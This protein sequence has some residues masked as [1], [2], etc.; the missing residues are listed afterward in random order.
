MTV[1]TDVHKLHQLPVNVPNFSKIRRRMA[2][3]R[4]A[5]KTKLKLKLEK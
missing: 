4:L 5:E 1:G 2:E 3:I